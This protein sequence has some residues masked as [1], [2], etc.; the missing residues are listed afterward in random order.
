M[1]IFGAL[2][3]LLILYFINEGSWGKAFLSLFIFVV[4]AAISPQIGNYFSGPASSTESGKGEGDSTDNQQDSNP[5]YTRRNESGEEESYTADNQEYDPNSSPTEYSPQFRYLYSDLEPFHE[6]NGFF[7]DANF[8][9][10]FGNSYSSGIV[11]YQDRS[12]GESYQ[13]YKIDQVYDT[14]SFTAVARCYSNASEKY[15]AY[16]YIYA[17]DKIIYS[18]EN[19]NVF[20]YPQDV[21]LNIQGCDVLKIELYGEGNDLVSSDG[22]EACLANPKITRE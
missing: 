14:L 7:Y 20:Y 8:E 1:Y 16:I 5:F 15:K 3:L 18:N 11:G 9:D 4:G 10:V 22:V 17:D 19:L 12:E 6:T 2:V 21:I 13:L